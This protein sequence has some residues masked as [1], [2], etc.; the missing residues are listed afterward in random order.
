[1]SARLLCSFCSRSET[2]VRKLVAGGGGG[3]ICDEC[4]AIAA[5]IIADSDASPGAPGWWQRVV[6]RMRGAARP[7][8]AASTLRT[9]AA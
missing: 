5:R 6:A 7:E 3:H 4:V 2:E 9:N 8:R 1:M